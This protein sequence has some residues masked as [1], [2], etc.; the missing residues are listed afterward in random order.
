MKKFKLAVSQAF[1]IV[2]DWTL[3]IL[4]CVLISGVVTVVGFG[5]YKIIL[6]VGVMKWTVY[7]GLGGILIFLV[8]MAVKLKVRAEQLIQKHKDE[9]HWQKIDADMKKKG[10]VR[11]DKHLPSPEE[12]D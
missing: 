10:I 4:L 3:S 2:F 12:V 8:V 5:A 1:V 9:L 7:F 11:M 6:D